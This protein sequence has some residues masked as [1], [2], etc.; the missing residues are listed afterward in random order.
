MRANLGRMRYDEEAADAQPQA[1][2]NALYLWRP[3]GRAVASVTVQSRWGNLYE[4]PTTVRSLAVDLYRQAQVM[5]GLAIPAASPVADRLPGPALRL[6]AHDLPA[7]P[8]RGRF[9]ILLGLGEMTDLVT[10]R[11]TMIPQHHPHRDEMRVLI[12]AAVPGAVFAL[13]RAQAIQPPNV[14]RRAVRM[15]N[16]LIDATA[17][18]VTC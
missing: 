8:F 6:R 10:A 4:A 9:N 12:S 15:V 18:Q 17:A 5:A 2:A 7:P 3:L 11:V 13:N 1:S 14:V 16:L